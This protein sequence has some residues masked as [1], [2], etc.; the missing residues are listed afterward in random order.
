MFSSKFNR[1][2][3]PAYAPEFLKVGK[4]VLTR[5]PQWPTFFL[6]YLA[7]VQGKRIAYNSDGIIYLA[8]PNTTDGFILAETVLLG[9]YT[10]EGFAIGPSDTIVDVGAHAGYFSLCAATQCPQGRVY[11][12]EPNS[13]NYALLKENI[14]INKTKNIT[15]IRAAVSGVEGDRM[16][17]TCSENTGRHSL[18]AGMAESKQGEMVQVVTLQSMMRAHRLSR[19]DFLKIDCEGEEESIL[20]HCPIDVLK[21]IQRVSMECHSAAGSKRTVSLK[22]HLEAKGFS[23]S[24][25]DWPGLNRTMLY[26]VQQG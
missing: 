21:R 8:R 9:D 23:V 17:Y 26:A 3:Q 4:A 22:K 11:A 18:N 2:L 7:L 24:L 14:A 12:C 20:M 19:I 1:L 13:A 5:L 15:A 6:D 25:R 16:L 10:P